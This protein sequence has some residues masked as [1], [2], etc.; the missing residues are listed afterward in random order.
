MQNRRIYIF[1]L[2]FLLSSAFSSVYAQDESFGMYFEFEL[3]KKISKKFEVSII[4]DVRLHS[5]FYAD[6]FQIDGKLSYEPYKFLSF[7]TAYRIKTNFKDKGNE[8]THRWV[9]D[10]ALSTDLGRFTPSF[11]T[12][13]TTHNQ[14]E[15]KDRLT[16]IRPRLKVAY[17]IK[18]NKITPY[19][20]YEIYYS[21]TEKETQKGR[22]DLGF[23]RKIGDI[24]RIGIYYRFQHYYIDIPAV[25]ILG[26][27]YRIKF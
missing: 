2:L 19:T 20:A 21:T 14:Y 4:P 10:A 15:D 23:T 27:D 12:R 8:T 22:F 11:R 18:G 13:V 1:L 5:N 17:N 26:I 24:H 9:F 25:N 16:Y 3:T 7:A 6:K